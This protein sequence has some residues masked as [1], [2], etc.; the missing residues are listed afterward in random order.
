MPLIILL[1]SVLVIAADQV[2]KLL[3]I[4]YLKPDGVK[5]I[6]DGLLSFVYVE[7]RGAAFSIL[8][9]QRWLFIG[10]TLV[11]CILIIYAL[12]R[13]GNHEFFSYAASALIV[14]GGIGN[15]IDRILKGFVVD[16]IHVSFFPAIFNFG[17]CCVTVGTVFLMIHVLFFADDSHG[18]EKVLRTK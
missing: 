11:I 1:L 13:Y 3:V 18:A 16:Y 4:Q 5:T 17:D 12:F 10:I 7:N 15:L 8:Q 6:F 2:L 9:N 14:G